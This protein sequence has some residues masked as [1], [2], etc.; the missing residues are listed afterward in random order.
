MAYDADG[1]REE[2]EIDVALA[3]D[4]VVMA[5]ESQ[6]DVGIL[7]SQDR[8]FLPALRY[9]RDHT[10]ARADIAGWVGGGERVTLQVEGRKLRQHHLGENDYIAVSDDNDY[11]RKPKR[12]KRRRR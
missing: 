8:D 11:R 9:V 2:K 1:S 12:R 6:Y 5:I 10:A 7:F 3:I 4:L